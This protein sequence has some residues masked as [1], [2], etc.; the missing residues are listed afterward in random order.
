VP[1]ALVQTFL[2]PVSNNVN[3]DE[4]RIDLSN[5]KKSRHPV[6]SNENTLTPVLGRHGDQ[7]SSVYFLGL[8]HLIEM[9]TLRSSPRGEREDP[10]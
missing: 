9:E 5:V 7:M 4:F 3:M 2:V 6:T 8:L 10:H 1:Q